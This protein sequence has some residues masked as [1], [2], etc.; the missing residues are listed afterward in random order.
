VGSGIFDT[1]FPLIAVVLLSILLVSLV[2]C[3]LRTVLHSPKV[4]ATLVRYEI[5]RSEGKADGQPFYHPVVQFETEEGQFL[6]ATSS[7]GN[8]REPW[9]IGQVLQVRYKPANPQIIEVECFGNVW[10]LPLTVGALLI[11]T[12]VVLWWTT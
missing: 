12:S 9:P 6:I 11:M 8:W 10:G 1:A 4:S 2:V 3:R 7:W 5:T